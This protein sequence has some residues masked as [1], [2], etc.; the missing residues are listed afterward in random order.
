MI[1]ENV[2]M[3]KKRIEKIEKIKKNKPNLEVRSQNSL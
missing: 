1:V 2:K 3:G